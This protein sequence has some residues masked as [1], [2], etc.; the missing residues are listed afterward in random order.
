ML[1]LF[2]QCINKISLKDL[3]TGEFLWFNKSGGGGGKSNIKSVYIK[4]SIAWFLI[5]TEQLRLSI[6]TIS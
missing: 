3:K 4:K 6:C 2:Q 1:L 5:K